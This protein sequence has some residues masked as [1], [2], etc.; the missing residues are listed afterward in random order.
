MIHEPS[1]VSPQQNMLM[2]VNRTFHRFPNYAIFSS[3]LSLPLTSVWTSS[4][5]P[6][7][8][9]L[10]LC[11]TFD[12]TNQDSNPL[13][14]H[15]TSQFTAPFRAPAQQPHQ[16]TYGPFGGPNQGDQL[17]RPRLP[18]LPANQWQGRLVSRNPNKRG[19]SRLGQ[20]VYAHTSKVASRRKKLCP[21]NTTSN[22]ERSNLVSVGE[23]WLSYSYSSASS[24]VQ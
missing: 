7:A 14:Q 13:W 19:G 23:L 12:V 2:S 4:T 10:N 8:Q 20:A 9:T 18:N 21:G 3:H 22:T 1:I 5:I 15:P 11:A 6:F 16:P 17:S 24:E